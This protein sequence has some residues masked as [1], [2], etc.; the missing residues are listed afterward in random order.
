MLGRKERDQLELYMCGSLRDL[1]PDYHVLVK[2]DRVL[3]LSWLHEEVAELYA[4][5]FGRPGIDPASTRK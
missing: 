3:D 4:A 1:V 5:G 2:V